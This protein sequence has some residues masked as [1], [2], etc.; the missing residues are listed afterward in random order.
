MYKVP[1]SKPPRSNQDIEKMFRDDPVTL[2]WIGGFI[3]R[4]LTWMSIVF[5]SLIIYLLDIYDNSNP[6]FKRKNSANEITFTLYLIIVLGGVFIITKLLK[7]RSPV[8]FHVIFI[9]FAICIINISDI[10]WHLY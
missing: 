2:A 1:N 6:L 9:I 5:N 8:L 10:L 4:C 7:K 3:L